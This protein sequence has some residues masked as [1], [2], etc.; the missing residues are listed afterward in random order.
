MPGSQY[1]ALSGLRARADELDRLASDIANI[2]TSGYKAERQSRASA[3]RPFFL[4]TLQTAIDTTAGETRMDMTSGALAPTGRPLDVAIDGPGFFA[5]KTA[6]GERY[7]RNG[8]FTRNTAGQLA[9]ESGALVLGDNNEPISLGDGD[10]KVTDDG[11]VWNGDAQAGK[12]KL[13]S[14]ADPSRLR[15]EG[16]TMFSSAGQPAQKLD[17][18]AVKGGS[19][20][21]SNVSVAGRLAELTTVSRGFEAMQ[22]AVSLMLNDIDG[23][24]IEQLGRR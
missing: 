24:A 10:L 21:Q 4:D 2:G 1:I 9:T 22:K 12:L 17:S 11:T 7:T 8:H 19:L 15:P 5:V 20:E 14:F 6:A 13:V 16:T 18:A 3:E 23:K